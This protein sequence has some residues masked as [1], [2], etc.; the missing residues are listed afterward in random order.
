MK[1]GNNISG[2]ESDDIDNV[3]KLICKVYAG[4][5][6]ANPSRSQAFPCGYAVGILDIVIARR[7]Q[8]PE[9]IDA[10]I[11]YGEAMSN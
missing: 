2:Q 4:I 9:I 1:N 5:R 6:T 7:M 8:I 11:R 3:L 10:A